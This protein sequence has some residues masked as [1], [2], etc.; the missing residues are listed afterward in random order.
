MSGFSDLKAARAARQGRSVKQN[1]DEAKTP[2]STESNAQTPVE[3]QEMTKPIA[4]EQKAQESAPENKTSAGP[5]KPIIPVVN[6]PD[7]PSNHLHIRHSL[8]TGRGFYVSENARI[9]KAQTIIRTAPVVA[10]LSNRTLDS[11]CSHC[12]LSPYE[13]SVKHGDLAGT[14]GLTETNVVTRGLKKC[15]GCAVVRYCS[16][17][18]ITFCNHCINTSRDQINNINITIF[19]SSLFRPFCSVFINHM[20]VFPLPGMSNSQ[21][22]I[23][24]NRV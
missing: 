10:V 19:I 8:T 18:S 7:F 24:R 12:W 4:S 1:G 2:A 17:V 14:L 22:A 23:P 5:S 3:E 16:R 11:H 6:Y 13:L 20:I 9:T 15:G 21:L